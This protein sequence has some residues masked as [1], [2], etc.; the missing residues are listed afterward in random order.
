ML[1]DDKTGLLKAFL[2][3]LPG[4]AAAR[5]A[6]AVEVDKLMDGHALPH[7][8]IL[9]GLRPVLRREHYERAPTPLRLF[10][11][12]FQDLLTCHPRKVKQKGVIAR[13]T[14]VPC[15]N[16]LSQT[17]LPA[18]TQVY[19]K[20]TKAQ[21]LAHR[22]DAALTCASEFWPVAAKALKDALSTEAGRQSAQKVLG[23]AFAVADAAEMALLLSVGGAVEKVQA[24]LPPPV[25]SFSDQLIWQVREIYEKLMD[26]APDA[27][28]YLPVIVMTRLM[29][30]WE[31]LRMPLRLARHTDE[32]MISKTDM[33]LVGEI[34][35]TRMD[36]LRTAIQQTRHPVFE[37]ET[38]L[39][40]ART[41]ADLSS[42]IVKEIELK[43]QGEWGKRL[44]AER[45]QIGKVMENFMDRASREF[46]ASL[47]IHKAAGADFSKPLGAEKQAMALR[48]A[49]LVAG[50]RPFA[51][52][53]SFAAKQKDA[54]DELC[55]WLRRYNEDLVKTLKAEPHNGAANAQFPLC[56]ELTV[57]LFSEEEAELLRR[58]GRAALSTAA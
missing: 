7:Q 57:L 14:L 49:K 12:P 23:D 28:A 45:V 18:E 20:E 9:D 19:I 43:R 30:P 38:L 44:L 46:S 22:L 35:F 54:N 25:P 41:F 2:G 5:L 39:D 13:G 10:C 8:D 53:A 34:L 36:E 27:A 55:A 26:T 47:P 37:A 17:L 32:T 31:A 24:L 16:W 11:R 21:V 6:M 52:A 29:R 56:I 42:N 48:Y 33:G 1:S 58:R 50:S 3:N 4:P 51:A 40:Q 15:W